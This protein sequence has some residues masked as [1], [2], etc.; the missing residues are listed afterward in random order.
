[1]KTRRG[2]VALIA[3]ISAL[4]LVQVMLPAGL[5]S[6][7]GD[8]PASGGADQG[9][10]SGGV[11]PD[12]VEPPGG[13]GSASVGER[14]VR[15]RPPG[16][17]SE[18]KVPASMAD[19]F[20]GE[21][22]EGGPLPAGCG[23]GDGREPVEGDR[24][25]CAGQVGD[26]LRPIGFTEPGHIY[27]PSND[28]FVGAATPGEVYQGQ[29]QTRWNA[30]KSRT[31]ML[32]EAHIGTNLP[33]PDFNLATMFAKVVVLDPDPSSVGDQWYQY[34]SATVSDGAELCYTERDGS[35]SDNRD[36][37]VTMWVP[38]P[39]AS[40]GF[41]VRVE[42]RS[43]AATNGPA[44]CRIAGGCLLGN[45]EAYVHVGPRPLDKFES[46]AGAVGLSLDNGIIQ[47]PAGDNSDLG[48]DDVS[49]VVKKW[50]EDFLPQAIA[51][52][53]P[54]T[55]DPDPSFFATSTSTVNSITAPEAKIASLR[56]TPRQPYDFVGE[57]VLRVAVPETRVNIDLSVLIFSWMWDGA[58]VCDV[59]AHVP[60]SAAVDLQADRNPSDP[61][62][63]DLRLAGHS[64]EVGEVTAEISG[65]RVGTGLLPIVR[66][67]GFLIRPQIINGVKD[68]VTTG[69][70]EVFEDP[71]KVLDKIEPLLAAV[72]ISNGP[73]VSTAVG[74]ST[75][76]VDQGAYRKT[77][78]FDICTA[79]VGMWSEGIDVGA[80]LAVGD[81]MAGGAARRF[82]VTAAVEATDPDQVFHDRERPDGSSFDLAA[83]IHG[84]TVN[85]VLSALAEG[86]P[87]G[88][89]VLDVD[90]PDL[91][92]HPTVAPM[93]LPSPPD[94]F[95]V[96]GDVT[97]F[98]PGLE[99]RKPVLAY[100]TES[101]DLRVGFDATLDPASYTLQPQTEVY[102]SPRG[103]QLDHTINWT[104]EWNLF[105]DP[106][107]QYW[108]EHELPTQL[109]GGLLQ[110]LK[111]DALEALFEHDLLDGLE[112][113]PV[114]IGSKG[115][116][117]GVWVDV[118]STPTS[119]L[120]GRSVYGNGYY[121]PPTSVEFTLDPLYFPDSG[122]YQVSWTIV[123]EVRGLTL[124]QSPPSGEHEL[125]KVIE[126]S[127]IGYTGDD[128][129]EGQLRA[130][131]T[132]SRGGR[133]DTA[134]L[135]HV[136]KLHVHP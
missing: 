62:D 80:D 95:G 64:V 34:N 55:T 99:M 71:T 104:I 1:M 21:V 60:I 53:P 70:N 75:V 134:Q 49:S 123:D 68:K 117:L 33:D 78:I 96:G 31:E 66:C 119:V 3:T 16:A 4:A 61:G 23:E 120:T 133:S 56:L 57:H 102:M 5:A 131:V 17:C 48:P 58:L 45:D 90:N 8:A 114:S 128:P 69:I 54:W 129:G 113:G 43:N 41:T 20:G 92:I 101:V 84:S 89:G 98:V 76:V 67:D 14:W 13:G 121:Q 7:L 94:H 25:A 132:V 91:T 81:G 108:F 28:S 9:R 93:Y 2:A 59:T 6:A 38:L 107:F 130:Q 72:D 50:S 100:A 110:P 39:D 73:L 125:V 10:P 32:I 19:Q 26:R 111:I 126:G 63:L 44:Q 116:Y 87:G 30:A 109:V 40:P 42:I 51:S 115:G 74:N 85:Q 22:A 77:C 103:L 12:G 18:G 86:G 35:D 83:H 124:Y 135:T 36:G 24:G 15:V 29:V 27:T 65:W 47:E 37:Y 106:A 112:L 97:L 118:D 11:T 122:F 105:K 127:D 46:V 136:V 82:P 79:D 88:G 52:I